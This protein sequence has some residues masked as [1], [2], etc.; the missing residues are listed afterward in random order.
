MN[1]RRFP[2]NLSKD[3]SQLCTRMVALHVHSSPG[4]SIV[5][6]WLEMSRF[7]KR[8][9]NWLTMLLQHR[10]IH[11]SSIRSVQLLQ[12]RITKSSS[13]VVTLGTLSSSLVE[14]QLNLIKLDESW[15]EILGSAIDLALDLLYN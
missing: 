4:I 5:P 3:I 12:P 2:L 1:Q 9:A 14:L 6:F 13:C 15:T 7:S 8:R 11:R 10:L